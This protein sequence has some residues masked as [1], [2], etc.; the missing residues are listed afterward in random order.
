MV[1]CMSFVIFLNVAQRTL[2]DTRDSNSYTVRKL[3]DGNC[4]MTTNLNLSLSTGVAVTASKNDGSTFSFT[5]TSC[6]DGGAC[7]MNNN[8]TNAHYNSTWVYSWYAATAGQGGSKVGHI[9]GS[10]CPKGWRLPDSYYPLLK[11]TYNIANTEAGARRL[12]SSPLSFTRPGLTQGAN[13]W[14]SDDEAIYHTNEA[15]EES[16]RNS[17]WYGSNFVYVSANGSKASGGRIRCV[18]R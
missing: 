12:E 6:E 16:V 7:P 4:W 3:A 2:S 10:I 13:G 18:A 11:D 1:G 9:D 8:T 14:Y 15:A 5:P 17:L